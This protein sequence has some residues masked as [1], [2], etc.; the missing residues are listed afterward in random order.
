MSPTTVTP[1]AEKPHHAGNKEGGIASLFVRRPV[2]AIVLN[3]LI[4]IAGLA[5][6]QGIEVRELPS[7]DQPIIT[8]RTTYTGASPETI[9]RQVTAVIEGAVARVPGVTAVQSQS[10]AGNSRVTVTFDTKS[11]INV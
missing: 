6:Y 7:V 8:I 1:Q 5:A 10:S 4:V 11:D 3:I 9:D 2:F